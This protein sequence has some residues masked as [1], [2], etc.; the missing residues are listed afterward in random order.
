MYRWL[1]KNG[2]PSGFQTLCHNCNWAKSRG[3]CPHQRKRVIDQMTTTAVHLPVFQNEHLSVSRLRRL[4]ECP[5]AFFL[6]Y[7]EKPEPSLVATDREAADFGVVLHDALEQT[8]AW[9]LAE[10]YEGQFPEAVL[11]EH[12]R[13]AWVSSGIVGVDLYQEGRDILRRYVQRIGLV[14]HMRTLAV[15]KEFNM[16]LG[17]GTCRLVDPTEKAHWATRQ[18]YYVVNGFIDRIDRVDSETVEVVD[19]KS[20]R[21]LF[22]REELDVDLQMSIYSLAVRQ[23]YPW[24][25]RVQLAFDMLRHDLRQTTE[26]SEEDLASAVDYVLAMGARSEKGPYVARL[27]THCGTCDHRARC[28]TY[29][30]AVEQKLEVVAVSVSDL[31]ALAAERER[32]AKIAKAAYARKETLDGILKNALG[33]AESLELGGVVYRLTQFFNTTYPMGELLTLFGEVDIDLTPALTV[34]NKAL[35]AILDRVENDERIPRKVR[36]FFRV[37]VAAKSIKSPQRPRL[38]ARQKK[39]L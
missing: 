25:K 2:F 20:G 5:Y 33:E 11:L 30:L 6:Q 37:R 17:P 21:M 8:Y 38:D 36:D 14:D 23:I 27:N 1:E 10:E 13:L 4:E 12:F 9:I 3:G 35:D 16:L 19:Y 24:A 7:V 18:G 39:S 15:E 22:A 34:D 31:T 26:R 29:K 28:E 32:V